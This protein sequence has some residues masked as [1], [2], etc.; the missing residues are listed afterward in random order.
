[1]LKAFRFRLYPTKAQQTKINQMLES[2]RWVYNETLAV[3]K[4]SWEKQKKSI[5]L[6]QTNKMLTQWKKQHPELNDVFSQVLQDAQVRVDLAFQSFFRRVKAGEKKVG[7][8]RFK[9]FRRYDS[10]TYPQF[11]FKLNGDVLSLSKIGNIKIGLHRPVEGVVHRITI[12]RASEA[13]IYVAII[14]EVETKPKP[15]KD[16]A[17]AG[18]DVGLESFATLSNGEKIANPRF[19]RTEEH[20]LAKA[21]RKLSVEEKGST[22]WHKR[23]RVVQRV[24]E[25]IGNKRL[26]FIHQES[27]RLVNRFGVIAFE[28][29]SVKDMMQ[30]GNFAKNIGDAGWSMF[31]NATQS[32]AEEA[33]SRVVLVNP[34]GTSQGCSRCGLTVKKDLSVRI[35]RCECG[36]VLDR[37]LNAAINILRLGLQ[38]L[39]LNAVEAHDLQSWE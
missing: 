18:V 24:H 17:V 35:H 39:G 27:R 7:Y 22:K 10:L 28:K 31:V 23:L 9:G 20:E 16:G 32:K 4:N 34:N 30:N 2:L 14:T 13:K 36:L 21:Q 12:R 11:G 3:R 1:V 33:G 37:D 8:P 5:S 26:N 29:L 15:F 19:F 25:R 6:T 38:S